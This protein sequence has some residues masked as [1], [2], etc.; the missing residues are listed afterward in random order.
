MFWG[1]A[2]APR[3]QNADPL[4]K[5]RVHPLTGSV[6]HLHQFLARPFPYQDP[7]PLPANKSLQHPYH[8]RRARCELLVGG[9]SDTPAPS[10]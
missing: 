10:E 4:F 8:E 1:L 3:L 6:F 7:I 9:V 2:V 5:V